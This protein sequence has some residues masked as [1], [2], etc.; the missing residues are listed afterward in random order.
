MDID[1]PH[2]LCV[3]AIMRNEGPYLAEWIDFHQ[4]CGV[5]RFILYDNESTDDTARI[6]QPYLA[7]GVVTLVPWP[8]YNARSRR[9]E[10]QF[11]AYAHALTLMRGQ[12]RWLAFIDLDEFLFS[13]TGSDLPT[14]LHDYQDLPAVVAFWATFASSGHVMPPAA[15]LVDSYTQ[16]QPHGVFKPETFW[17]FYFKSIV[18]P[19]RA[20]GVI[21]PHVF[22]T[23]ENLIRGWTEAREPVDETFTL[24]RQNLTS[25]LSCDRLRINHYYTKSL[26][27]YRRRRETDARSWVTNIDY[28][29]PALVTVRERWETLN[30]GTVYDDTLIRVREGLR[31]VSPLPSVS[32]L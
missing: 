31:S 32:E 17:T 3:A 26:E 8:H 28:Y 30:E 22:V 24:E 11:E 5:E 7:R 9:P 12:T 29:D 19:H 23:D 10:L 21:N 20:R 15:G 16:R 1:P 25:L 13:P 6:L 4:L 2:T 14:V 27:E 18:Q